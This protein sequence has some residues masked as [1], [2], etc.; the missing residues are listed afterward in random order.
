MS[1][2]DHRDEAD[3][4]EVFA[5]EAAVSFLVSLEPLIARLRADR[6]HE[7]TTLGQLIDER[8]R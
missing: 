6:H 4:A 7:Q 8:L 1:R 5:D 3:G 2:V